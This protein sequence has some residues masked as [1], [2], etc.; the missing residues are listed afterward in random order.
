V[1]IF[2]VG[3]IG[4]SMLSAWIASRYDIDATRYV[5]WLL[6]LV[7]LW[8]RLRG[9]DWRDL[10]M[11]MGWHRGRGVIIESLCGVTGHIAG[12]PLLAVGVVCVMLLSTFGYEAAHHPLVDELLGASWSDV[13]ALY[14]LACVWAPLVEESL[15]RGAFYHHLR[16]PIGAVLSAGVTGFVFAVIHPQGIIAVAALMSLG[17]TFAM[18]REW[19]GSLVAPIAAHAFNNYAA[20]TLMLLLL[21]G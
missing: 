16:R 6:P 17:F 20:V 13:V 5:I 10:R 4:V 9:M 11:A 8:P 21:G 3:L 2:L 18:L 14:I 12:L 1:A 19:R 7:L 15:F